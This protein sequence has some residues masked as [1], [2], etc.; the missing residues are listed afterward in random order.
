MSS[1]NKFKIGDKFKAID[2]SHTKEY[3]NKIYTVYEISN[4]E[5]KPTVRGRAENFIDT[6]HLYEYDCEFYIPYDIESIEKNL[7]ILEKRYER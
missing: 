4:Y 5:S 6:V 7:E 1:I 2:K 3:I